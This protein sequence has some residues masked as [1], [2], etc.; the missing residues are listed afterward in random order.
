MNDDFCQVPLFLRLRKF[1]NCRYL[2]EDGITQLNCQ[3][4]TCPALWLQHDLQI[5]LP[6]AIEFNEIVLKLEDQLFKYDVILGIFSP[7][8]ALVHYVFI[9]L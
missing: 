2:I 1:T 8:V 4:T 3:L 5:R 6:V 9:T 7:R